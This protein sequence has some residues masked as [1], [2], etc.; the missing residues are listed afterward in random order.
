MKR[1]LVI[2]GASGSGKTC[3]AEAIRARGIGIHAFDDIGVPDPP[4]MIQG[5]GSAESW[6]REAT[7]TWLRKLAGRAE[8]DVEIL[9]GQMG[10]PMLLRTAEEEAIP[11]PEILLLDC[12]DEE[13]VRRLRRRGQPELADAGM[14]TWA[15]AFRADARLH[16]VPRL[17]TT[18]ADVETL[19]SEILSWLGIRP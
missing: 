8:A 17:D 19:A 14:A 12:S 1:I 2:T 13:R 15:E 16:G 10:I 3:A 9:E 5:F 6:Q 7:R 11:R 18:D 4:T